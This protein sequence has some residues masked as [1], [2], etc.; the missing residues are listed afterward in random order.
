MH[1]ENPKPSGFLLSPIWLYSLQ[2]RPGNSS[3][4]GWHGPAFFLARRSWILFRCPSTSIHNAVAGGRADPGSRC[5]VG[6]I[7]G[8]TYWEANGRLSPYNRGKPLFITDRSYTE[9]PHPVSHT[10]DP[11]SRPLFNGLLSSR[12]ALLNSQLP[13]F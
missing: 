6:C 9:F 8:E 12:P 4:K 13:Y 5:S 11:A 10:L 3:G 2:R 1:N 7:C